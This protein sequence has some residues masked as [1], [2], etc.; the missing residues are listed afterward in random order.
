MKWDENIGSMEELKIPSHPNIRY[1]KNRFK[2]KAMVS[3]WVFFERV[4]FIEDQDA[5]KFYIFGQ[6]IPEAKI[7]DVDPSLSEDTKS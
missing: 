7:K 6:S 5:K 4:I 2:Q 1:H 3:P